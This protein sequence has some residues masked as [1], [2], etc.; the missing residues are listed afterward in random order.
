M[1]SWAKMASNLDSHPR[2]RAAGR[3]GR[4]V[5][6]FILRRNAELDLHGLVPKI[7]VEP[8]YVAYELMI[9][10]VTAR[11]GVSRCVTAGLLHESETCFVISGWDDEW[12]KKPLTN[13]ERQAKFREKE[14]AKT[15]S[16]DNGVTKVTESNDA[17]VT[18]RDRNAGEE[19]RVEEKRVE[20]SKEEVATALPAPPPKKPKARVISPE[21]R[22][23]AM[24]VLGKLT[25]RSHVAYRSEKHVALIVRQLEAGVTED[26]LRRVIAYCAEKL[27]WQ[28]DPKMHQF[29]RPKTLFGP[30]KIHD[31]IDEAREYRK[32][33]TVPL[34]LEASHG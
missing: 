18:E 6:L 11:N 15:G 8:W 24:R 27:E 7:H 30:E 14:L 34:T 19:R 13:A 32:H 3:D 17:I 2:V 21:H 20:E 33:E 31:Y 12:A 26:E 22:E 25:Q 16:C 4:E 9:D 29:L 1:A 10:Q 23:I 5:Y 28:D